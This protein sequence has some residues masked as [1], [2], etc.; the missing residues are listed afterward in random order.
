[1][2]LSSLRNYKTFKAMTMRLGMEGN[3]SNDSVSLS[4]K[5]DVFKMMVEIQRHRSVRETLVDIYC[6]HIRIYR[7]YFIFIQVY[8]VA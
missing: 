2:C 4:T 7:E 6:A 5:Y 8:F 3:Y 1:M